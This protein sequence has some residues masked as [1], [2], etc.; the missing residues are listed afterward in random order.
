MKY[1]ILIPAYNPD[2]KLLKL[3]KEIDNQYPVIVINDGSDKITNDIFKT[4]QKYAHVIT[5]KEN[6]GK[7]YALKTG[8]NYIDDNYQDYIIVTMDA[9]G[10]HALKD[11]INLGDIS[12]DNPD[13]LIIGK[14]D[15]SKN[16]PLRSRIGNHITRKVFKMK[17]KLSIYDTQSGLRAFSYQLVDYM[18]NVPGYRYE[19]EMNVLLYLND[20]HIKH[21]EV[22]IETIYLNHNR[23]SHFKVMRDSYLIYKNIFKYRRSRDGR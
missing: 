3:L 6:M 7:G 19:Y 23:S 18:L 5:Y 2:N 9:D 22:P 17:T 20:N 1:I 10:Q 21:K 11:A 15:F 16:A 14:R 8:I 13:T 12:K 4:A